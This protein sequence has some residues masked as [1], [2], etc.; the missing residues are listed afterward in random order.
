MNLLQK[1]L[2]QNILNIYSLCKS[3]MYKKLYWYFYFKIL[4]IVQ[5]YKKDMQLIF[6]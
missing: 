6:I 4:C 2:E 5:F 1:I 3:C